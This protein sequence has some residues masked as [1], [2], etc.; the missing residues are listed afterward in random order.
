MAITHPATT[1]VG[2]TTG[3]SNR[4]L[5][6][7]EP[8]QT[9]RPSSHS[10]RSSQTANDPLVYILR[11]TAT[12]K[13]YERRVKLGN[14]ID[15]PIVPAL[16]TSFERWDIRE[17]NPSTLTFLLSDKPRDW[18]PLIHPEVCPSN[19]SSEVPRSW[20]LQG[21]FVLGVQAGGG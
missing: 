17:A 14:W 13:R 5:P 8:A 9:S 2:P 21:C 16:T 7:P 15:K 18:T 3:T 10:G 6:Q 11:P 4:H 20:S 1:S 12:V 19:L